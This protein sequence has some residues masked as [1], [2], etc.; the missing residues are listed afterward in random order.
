MNDSAARLAVLGDTE[1]TA[2]HARMDSYNLADS[3]IL[4]AHH[5]VTTEMLKRGLPHGHVD[6]AWAAAVLL[7]DEVVVSVKV[8]LALVVCERESVAEDVSVVAD[9]VG[10]IELLVDTDWL[11]MVGL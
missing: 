9:C 10:V 2:L 1:L 7:V 4:Q 6:D 5:L 8:R 11:E 3:A